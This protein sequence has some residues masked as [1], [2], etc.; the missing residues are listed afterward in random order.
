MSLL[1]IVQENHYDPWGWN[2][3]GIET[4]GDPEHKWQYNGKE[5]IE[6]L[7]LYQSD[8]GARMYD[9][10]FGRWYVVDPFA[11]KYPQWSPY[12]T[13]ANNPIMFFD[14]DV[15]EPIRSYRRW[16]GEIRKAWQWY[17]TGVSDRLSSW[18]SKSFHGR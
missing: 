18:D 7:G 17:S 3:V 12:T 15:R 5:K 4:E 14:A 11:S 1:F 8:Y 13:M 9:G 2:L 10:V 16:F 6:D